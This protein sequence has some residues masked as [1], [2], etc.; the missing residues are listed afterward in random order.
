MND[1]ENF[2]ENLEYKLQFRLV[3]IGNYKRT[4]NKVFRDLGTLKVN[5]EHAESWILNMQKRKLSASHINNTA[6]ILTRY[7]K[8]I[9][10]EVTLMR[11][12]KPKPL[13][14]DTL[15]EGE[16]ARIIAACDNSRERA[17]ISL[18]AYSGV[19]ASELCNLKVKD[20]D[21]DNGVVQVIN[22]K[23]G[24]DGV[25]YI[26]RECC[27]MVSEYMKDYKTNCLLFRTLQRF[28][29]YSTWALRKLVKKVSRLARI[30]KRVYPHL[31]RHSLATNL[32]KKGANILTVQQQLRHENLETTQIYI[33]SFPERVQD[34]YRFFKPNYV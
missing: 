23:G 7:M 24:K 18:L 30:N 11:V 13:I 17:M 34:E 15:T 10:N 8:F 6:A 22:G 27:K 1:I 31:F 4:L 26:A 12:K 32:I 16:V 29:P 21:L 3:T 2:Y 33:R 25:S 9:G 20:L 28:N 19:R 14:K 5:K